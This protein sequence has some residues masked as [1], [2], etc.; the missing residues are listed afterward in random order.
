MMMI[1]IGSL[2]PR[3]HYVDQAD[4]ELKRSACHCLLSVDIKG[5]HHCRL[6]LMVSFSYQ[7]DSL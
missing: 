3:T 7:L 4:L 5:V 2:R 1:E 6:A